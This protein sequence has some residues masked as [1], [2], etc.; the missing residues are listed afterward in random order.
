MTENLDTQAVMLIAGGAGAALFLV[1]SVC[2]FLL[3]TK[4]I[5]PVRWKRLSRLFL[6]LGGVLALGGL[7]TLLADT[8]TANPGAILA[9]GAGALNAFIALF[10]Q[11]TM[12]WLERS[13]R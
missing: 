13:K 8:A 1:Q 6:L 10:H 12:A 4:R 5:T 3:R 9:F 2:W 11:R 7:L